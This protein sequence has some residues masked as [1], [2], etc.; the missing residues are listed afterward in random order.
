MRTTGFLSPEAG[1]TDFTG[2]LDIRQREIGS[3]ITGP[4]GILEAFA[5]GGWRVNLAWPAS[6]LALG[7][8]V[9]ATAE[10][11]EACHQ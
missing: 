1:K 4:H 3:W 10:P 2:S 9:A 7:V 6:L 5:L 8:E 11:E